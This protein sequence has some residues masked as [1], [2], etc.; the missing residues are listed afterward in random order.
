MYDYTMDPSGD[1]VLTLRNPNAPLAIWDSDEPPPIE[2]E[3]TVEPIAEPIDEPIGEPIVE[4]IVEPN[5]VPEPAPPTENGIL[6]ENEPPPQDDEAPLQEDPHP[7]MPPDEPVTFLVSSRHLVLASPVLK[8]MLTGGWNEGDRNN[9][10][11]HIC[12]EDWDA[13]ALAVVMNVLHSHYRQVPKTVT[14]EMLAKIAVIVDYYKVHEAL[15]IMASV[16]I[17]VLQESLPHLLGRDV[18]L[19]ILVS[20]VFGDVSIF[21]QVTKV[22]ILR[23]RGDVEISQRLPIP[24]A[25]IGKLL[26]FASEV[27]RIINNVLSYR[28]N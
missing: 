27:V 12:A 15:E 23:S 25:V 8:A 22:A 7:V 11:L 1:V 18:V 10:Q 26:E 28:P 13:K 6:A 21:K 24:P 14:L 16:W 4:P 5:T 2:T 9:G 17:K 3:P 20:W 19:W